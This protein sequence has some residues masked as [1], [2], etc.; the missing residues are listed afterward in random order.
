M[1]PGSTWAMLRL[2][3][4]C[5]PPGVF[6]LYVRLS[7]PSVIRVK[8]S[9]THRLSGP[10]SSTAGGRGF[11]STCTLSDG[12]VHPPSVWRAWTVELAT[13]VYRKGDPL[14]KGML[15]APVAYHEIRPDPVAV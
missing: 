12:L 3:P 11:T 15:L 8:P 14:P 4:T 13:G 7:A 2:A 5:G 6:Q 10:A 9:P 1:S